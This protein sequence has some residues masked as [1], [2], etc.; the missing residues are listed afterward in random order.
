[1][2]APTLVTGATGLVGHSIVK[3]LLAR[4][5]R[6]RVL[7]RSPER[8]SR[9]IPDGCEIAKGDVTDPDAVLAAARGCEVVYHAAGLPEQWLRDP[10]A[11]DAVNVGG[12]RN[13]IAAVRAH[14]VRRLMYTSTIDVFSMRPGREFDESHLASEPKHTH[15]Q[16]SKQ[17]SDR[18]VQEAVAEGLPAVFLHPSGVYGPGP[19]SSPGLTRAIG[20]IARGEVPLLLPGAVPVVYVEDIGLGHVLAEERGALGERFILSESSHN[21]M[22]F[23]RAVCAAAGRSKIPP[24]LP[25]WCARVFAAVSEVISSATGRPPIVARGQVEFLQQHAQPS[26]RLARERLGWRPLSFEQGL[27]RTL[28]HLRELGELPTESRAS[29]SV[30][31]RAR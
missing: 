28:E 31:E 23:A 19:A 4:K 27:A 7:V 14:G 17:A 5:R 12:T 21:L 24:T 10:R 6:V 16:R 3:E 2:A 25:L 30:K 1:M 22:E 15:Y 20:M 13:V 8:A 29:E 11:F 9:T 18:M 26:A